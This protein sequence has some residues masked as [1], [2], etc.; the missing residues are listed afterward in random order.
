MWAT[1]AV[2]AKSKFWYFLRKLRRVKKANGQ[3]ISA[4]EVRAWRR[5]C[6]CGG[7]GGG[8]LGSGAVR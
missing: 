7:G 3:I 1:D 6:V 5:V 4:N 2:C 8:A